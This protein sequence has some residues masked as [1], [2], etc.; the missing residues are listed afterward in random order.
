MG[1]TLDAIRALQEIELQIFDIRRQLARKE[2]FVT[3]QSAKAASARAA[4]EAE[5][6]EHKRAQVEM[7]DFDLTLKS[8]S[9]GIDKIRQQLLSIRNNKEYAA[10]LSQLNTEKAEVARIESKGLEMMTALDARKA[11]LDAHEK[12]LREEEQRLTELKN[13]FAAAQQSFAQKLA[14]LDAR[15][16]QAAAPIAPEIQTMFNRVAER[17]D[18]EAMARIVRSNPRRDEF[19]CEGCNMSVTADRYNAL[20][21]RDEIHTCSNCGR[22]LYVE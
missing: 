3:L 15:R 7:G 10:V 12:T 22:I 6:R 9:A 4:L 11:T 19:T 14:E 16:K 18:G 20:K 17:Y 1:V 21:T 13:Q 2:K 8:R 5:Q